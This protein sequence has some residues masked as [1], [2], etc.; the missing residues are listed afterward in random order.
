M[1]LL[2]CITLV[3]AVGC[4]GDN[5][6]GLCKGVSCPNAHA[7]CDPLDGQCKLDGTTTAVGAP[8]TTTG[9]DPVCGADPNAICNNLTQDGFPGGYCSFE[10]CSAMAPCPIGSSC[11]RLGG[12]AVGCFKNCSA[13]A[14]CRGPDYKCIDV[15]TLYLHRRTVAQALLLS[16]AALQHQQR[17]SEQQ[18]DLQRRHADGDAA[19]AG[20]L[21]L[22]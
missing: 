14:E 2:F 18:A 20:H 22:N 7:K 11:A 6:T 1:R 13:D 17:L 4:G 12:E 21:S 5:G 15:D 16:A 19:D 3:A 9:A 8:C 10:P